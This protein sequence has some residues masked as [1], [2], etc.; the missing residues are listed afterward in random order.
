M[1]EGVNKARLLWN[2]VLSTVELY[3][4]PVVLLLET[5]FEFRDSGFNEPMNLLPTTYSLRE[6][7]ASRYQI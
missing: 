4:S 5:T 2:I 1:F 7:L 3:R 6:S